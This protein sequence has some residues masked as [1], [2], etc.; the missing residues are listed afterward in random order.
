MNAL[1]VKT[2][3]NIA[4]LEV[5]LTLTALYFCPP[6][7]KGRPMQVSNTKLSWHIS[8]SS[9]NCQ[10]GAWIHCTMIYFSWH[11]F[12][13]FKQHFIF[14]PPG[15]NTY[16]M[17]HKLA[18]LQLLLE[19]KN[20]LNVKFGF[21]SCQKAQAIVTVWSFTKTIGQGQNGQSITSCIK[22]CDWR[23]PEINYF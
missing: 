19:K 22:I 21:H 15:R 12:W 5:C 13:A 23:G 11:V 2:G 3:I 18:G 8:S 7:K 6:L 9:W 14:T 10:Y 17:H 1:K 4:I 16:K 20:I